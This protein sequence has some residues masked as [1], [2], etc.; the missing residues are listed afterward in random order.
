MLTEDIRARLEQ[1]NRQRLPVSPPRKK[2]A[3]VPRTQCTLANWIPGAEVE[4]AAGRHYL[5]RKAL[6]HYL[7]DAAAQ[8]KTARPTATIAADGRETHPELSA[9]IGAFPARTMFLDLETCGFSGS[10][11]F[12]IGLICSDGKQLWVEQLLARDYTEE[13]AI[14]ESLWT[15]AAGHDVLVTFNGKSFDWPMVRDRSHFHRLHRQRPPQ[16]SARADGPPVHFDLLHHA[17]RRWKKKLPNCRLQTLERFICGRVRRG[18]IPGSR[19]PY[20]YHQ[21][22]RTGD[23]RQLGSIL[24]HNALDLVTLAQLALRMA[25][26]LGTD[27]RE[28]P[29]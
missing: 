12:L 28:R 5:V 14:L 4:S 20:E 18:D 23:A 13:R 8:W 24:H 17:R 29:Q 16:D 1:L 7:P 10:P 26:E 27:G 25:A 2:P 21:F 3:T 22:V 19:I 11:I 9:F 6:A 15:T